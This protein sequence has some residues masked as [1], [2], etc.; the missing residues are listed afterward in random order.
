R[1]IPMPVSQLA[2]EWFESGPLR[3][4]VA[5]G[6]VQDYRHGPRAGGTA[7][8]LLHH[9]VGAPAG[10]IRG[11][12]AWRAGPN[13]FTEA[14]GEA[15]RRRCVTVRTGGAVA[16][17]LVRDHAV[18]GVA[19]ETGEEL[20]ARYVLSALDPARTLLGLVDPVWLDPEL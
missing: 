19:L 5:A 15:A 13:A 17:I 12:G 1:T 11:R 6:G 10:T 8:V 4:A 3:A 7:F 14:A 9:L 2:E 20:R 16:R 18:R